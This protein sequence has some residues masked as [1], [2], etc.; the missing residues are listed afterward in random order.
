MGMKLEQF[1]NRK[2]R[3]FSTEILSW[4]LQDARSSLT[5]PDTVKRPLSDNTAIVFSDKTFPV[6]HLEVSHDQP[7]TNVGF[8]PGSETTE[9]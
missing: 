5:L 2:L 7:A 1:H 3:L 6:T 8:Q 9:L 4:I